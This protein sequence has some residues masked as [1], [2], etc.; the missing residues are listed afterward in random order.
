MLDCRTP[1]SF[2]ESNLSSS[3]IWCICLYCSRENDWR[4][5]VSDRLFMCRV[6]SS[7]MTSLHSVL[8]FFLPSLIDAYECGNLNGRLSQKREVNLHRFDS[9]T[10]AF[11]NI[12]T[13]VVD[14]VLQFGLGLLPSLS[15]DLLV[16]GFGR[17]FHGG[18]FLLLLRVL[19]SHGA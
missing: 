16:V 12:C 10:V 7:E 19:R 15:V 14:H 1:R 8:N 2:A 17:L 11:V 6:S 9:E 5:H 18:L 4:Y 13:E 3:E